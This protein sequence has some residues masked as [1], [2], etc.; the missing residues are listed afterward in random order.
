[1]HIVAIASLFE[2]RCGA[3]EVLSDTQGILVQKPKA[4]AALHLTALT[5]LLEQIDYK[6]DG[7]RY[8]RAVLMDETQLEAAF[9]HATVARL[10]E[11]T[12]CPD[13]VAKHMI[14]RLDPAA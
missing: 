9:R 10:L 4:G 6:G 12:G 11:Q 3:H 14:A 8:F 7:P 5:G 1:M 13:R 2:Q